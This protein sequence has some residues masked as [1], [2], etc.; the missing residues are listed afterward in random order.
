MR[1]APP[2]PRRAEA[3]RLPGEGGPPPS[4]EMERWRRLQGR[5]AS[6][7]PDLPFPPPRETVTCQV[8]EYGVQVT[9]SRGGQFPGG[10]AP[11][12]ELYGVGGGEVRPPL[13]K[14]IAKMAKA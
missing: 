10:W 12:P 3:G 9:V 8:S 1:G 11:A 13:R 5:G 7:V 4:A 6:R 14:C 2:L